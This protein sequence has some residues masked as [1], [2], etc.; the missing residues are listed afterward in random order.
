MYECIIESLY[1]IYV[2]LCATHKFE[3]RARLQLNVNKIVKQKGLQNK[4]PAGMD[5]NFLKEKLKDPK[6]QEMIKKYRN[7]HGL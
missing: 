6:I 4:I 7:Q 1:L 2:V 3:S 5:Q